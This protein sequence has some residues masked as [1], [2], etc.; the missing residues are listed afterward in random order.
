MVSAR[1]PPGT[2][3]IRLGGRIEL[4]HNTPSDWLISSSPDFFGSSP[5]LVCSR[6][7]ALSNRHSSLSRLSKDCQIVLK[8]AQAFATGKFLRIY[9]DEQTPEGISFPM[10]ISL[11]W[12]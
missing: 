1:M 6:R 10:P 3:A 7:P 11:L 4:H 8:F 12:P 9:A 2:F 5:T